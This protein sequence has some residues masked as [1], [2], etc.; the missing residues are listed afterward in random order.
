MMVEADYLYIRALPPWI[1]PAKGDAVGFHFGYIVPSVPEMAKISRRFFPEELGSLDL[2]PQTGNAPQLLHGDDFRRIMPLWAEIQEKVEADQEAIK[3]FNWVRDMYAYSFAVAKL[4]IRHHVPLVP[5]NH[6]MVQPPADVVV[7]E[8]AILHYTWGPIINVKG[9]VLWQFDKRQYQGG[10]GASGPV[11]LVKLD[12]PPPWREGMRLQ[13]NE[14]VTP[15]GLLLM[16]LF[17]RR[18]APAM[19]RLLRFRVA[20][21]SMFSLAV[22]CASNRL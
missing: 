13:A 20:P 1:L 8:G 17:V 14:T 21:A 18:K 22:S 12:H 7:G 4:G 16:D 9:N 19:P 6:M 15:D 5:F 11:K 10:Q 2:V 3:E